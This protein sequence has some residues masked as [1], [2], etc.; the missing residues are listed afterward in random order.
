M[1]GGHGQVHLDGLAATLGARVF[2][3]FPFGGRSARAVVAHARWHQR[4][5]LVRRRADSNGPARGARDPSSSHIDKAL[6]GDLDTLPPGPPPQL[7][8]RVP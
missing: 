6:I 2:N 4:E 5:S 1:G 3:P 8:F 7:Y